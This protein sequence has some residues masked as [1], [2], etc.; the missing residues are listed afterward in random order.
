MM[1]NMPHVSKRKLKERAEK[2]LTKS[3]QTVLTKI[4]NYQEIGSFLDSLLSDTER[5][6]LAKRLAIVVLLEEKIPESTIANVLSVTRETVARQRYRL[7]LKGVGYKIALKK[8]AEE[9]MLQSFKNLLLSFAR[10]YARTAGGRVKPG[11]LD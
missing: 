5:L 11:I 1:H 4:N 7:E 3:L 8:L 10:Y 2:E 6:M 9:K